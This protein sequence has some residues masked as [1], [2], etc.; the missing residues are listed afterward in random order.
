MTRATTFLFALALSLAACSGTEPKAGDTDADTDTDTDADTDTDT[1]TDTVQIPEAPHAVDDLTECDEG[2]DASIDVLSNDT[3]AEDDIDP[4]T[5]TFVD[6]PLYGTVMLKPDGEAGYRS[7][8]EETSS[9]SFTYTVTDFAGHISNTATVEIT[10]KPVNDP[11]IAVDDAAVASEGGAVFIDVATND[12]DPDDGVDPWSAVI[13]NQPSN[14]TA[15]V[16][17]DGTIDYV[18]DGSEAPTDSFSYTI[19]DFAGASSAPGRVEVS[20]T[21][22]NDA[23]TA[24]DDNGYAP[25]GDLGTINVAAND[26]DPDDAIDPASIAI[27]A[28]PTYGILAVQLDGTVDYTHDGSLNY[29]DAFSYTIADT[30]GAVSNVANVTM[31]ITDLVLTNL[32]L[33]PQDGNLIETDDPWWANKGYEFT[34]LQDFTI[35][36]G[37]WWIQL[38]VGGY[39]SLTIYDDTGALLARGTQGFGAGVGAEEWYQSDLNFDFVGGT[40]Y[41]ASFYTNLAGSSTFDRQDGPTYGYSVDGLIDNLT[42]RSSSVSGDYAS[43][44]WPDYFGNTWA[45]HQRLD[46]L[47]P[48]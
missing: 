12:T 5:I 44:E 37:A 11:P 15:T 29:V 30:T 22:I 31:A 4:T 21:P 13:V 43:E 32:E 8:G 3:D 7:N 28:Q 17:G 25:P 10:I 45:P 1:D 46:V 18:H 27:I 2:G 34:A 33:T 41:T 36:G 16:Q 14:G 20:L 40:T 23:P 38:P 26:T 42:H 6:E 48:P 24:N 39:V 19:S 47:G 35:T 9:D